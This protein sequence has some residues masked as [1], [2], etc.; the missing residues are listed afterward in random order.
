[1]LL[2]NTA[3][4][5]HVVRRGDT[6][7]KIAEQNGTTP[8][9][10]ARYNHIKDPNR[11]T[12]GQVV[13]F[14]PTISVQVVDRLHQPI[15]EMKLALYASGRHLSD[16]VTCA[17][18]WVKDVVL[19]NFS[20][21]L[22]VFVFKPTGEKKRVATIKPS[23]PPKTVQLVSPKVKVAA[24]SANM[25]GGTPQAVSKSK[26]TTVAGATN[27]AGAPVVVVAA[28]A[29]SGKEKSGV[30]WV[31]KFPTSK[32]LDD[33]KEPFK[34]S[35]Q[36]FVDAL[37]T[38][39]VTVQINATYR[40][41]ERSYLMHYCAEIARGNIDPT[42]VP[43]WPGVEIDWAHLD[44]SGVPDKK[45]AKA[46]AQAMKQAYA[47]GSNPVGKPGLSNHNKKM[48]MD[49]SLSG[50]VGKTAVNGDGDKVD[51]VTWNDVKKLGVTYDVYW[52]GANDR[53]HWSWNGR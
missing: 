53:P 3:G 48:A 31:N 27:K 47:I 19:P 45:A 14:E 52:F 13:K 33:L 26:A 7:A 32:S 5:Q 29:T 42:T 41:S 4:N 12:I 39:G 10:L 22:Q 18:G 2:M 50:Y 23:G 35:A 9:A 49:V 40:P 20:D 51:L 43:A 25:Q 6:L 1:M 36:E 17:E 44:E 15:P 16:V 34:T 38:A 11:I 28:P 21:V 46:A 37:R 30:S 8:D 24:V